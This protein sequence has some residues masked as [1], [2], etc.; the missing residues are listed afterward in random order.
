MLQKGV[1]AEL[2]FKHFLVQPWSVCA[3]VSFEMPN[4]AADSFKSALITVTLDGIPN[5][6]EVWCIN[7][8]WDNVCQGQQQMAL[9][10]IPPQTYPNKVQQHRGLAVSDSGL[11][12][13]RSCGTFIFRRV[14]FKPLAQEIE[15]HGFIARIMLNIY[16][17][18]DASDIFVPL[19]V[20]EMTLSI[21]VLQY[22]FPPGD[23]IKAN[24]KVNA[25]QPISQTNQAVGNIWLIEN[26]VPKRENYIKV[27][28]LPYES[29]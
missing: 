28:G 3:N 16:L 8:V 18:T 5:A 25:M 14:V 22:H 1:T 10:P 20:Q 7:P 23:F 19:S 21:Q 15:Q 27:H 17:Q 24:A 11:Y 6:N 29:R 12:C 4:R 9:A 26:S 13:R 2:L